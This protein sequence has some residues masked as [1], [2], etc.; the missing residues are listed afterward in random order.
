MK[1]IVTQDLTKRFGNLTAVDNLSLEIPQG[2]V[3][4]FLGPNGAGKT[5]TLKML[6]G[7][8]KPTNG[9]AWIMGEEVDTGTY[10]RHIGY[11]PDVPSF[12]NWMR[13]D[14]F[15]LFMG[16]L[17]GMKGQPLR[18]RVTELLKL[19]GL[20]QIRTRIGGFSRG[21]KQRLGLAQ[22]LIN[23]PK[24]LLLDEPTSAL[25]PIGRK[26]ILELI[27]SIAAETTVVLSTHILADAERIC[28]QVAI[29]DKGR[30]L[31]HATMPEL[32]KRFFDSVF[33]LQVAEEPTPLLERLKEAQWVLEASLESG[34]LRLRVQDPAAAQYGLPRLISEL[35]FGLVDFQMQEIT[36]EDIFVRLV[37][38]NGQ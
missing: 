18:E 29:L 14:E 7:F 37:R 1:A 26:E 19:V 24:V 28:D 20:S 32:K 31:V 4:G 33:T 34:K 13:A 22:A 11:L 30:L 8:T 5:T 3:F 27:R 16:E 2:I 25:D 23:R 9:R 17:V 35:G 36:L 15:L 21:M 12:Y 38:E 6:L 10:R